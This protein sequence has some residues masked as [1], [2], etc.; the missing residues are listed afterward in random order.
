MKES[1]MTR[2]FIYR[3]L[4]KSY[5]LAFTEF[6]YDSYHALKHQTEKPA[7]FRRVDVV[8]Y[9]PASHRSIAFELKTCQNES[10]KAAVAQA[11]DH[12]IFFSFSGIVLPTA[13]LEKR[14]SSIKPAADANDLEVIGMGPTPDPFPE[15]WRDF[16]TMKIFRKPNYWRAQK[17]EHQLL[18]SDFAWRRWN[19][20]CC[21][22]GI[23]FWEKSWRPRY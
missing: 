2:H 17:G 23:Q 8:L 5:P 19:A 4:S 12:K 1:S 21:T 10:W 22:N 6:G 14:W 7:G 18:P 16:A 3:R 9:N 15:D 20:D 11:I 13:Y